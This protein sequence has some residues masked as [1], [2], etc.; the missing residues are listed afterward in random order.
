M[1][2]NGDGFNSAHVMSGEVKVVD[3]FGQ[4]KGCRSFL[5]QSD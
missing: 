2:R 5:S 4:G 3:D 1:D